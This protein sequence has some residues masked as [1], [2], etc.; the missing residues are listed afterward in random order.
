MSAPDLA[1]LHHENMVATIAQIGRFVPGAVLRE[2]D[3]VMTVLTG[4]PFPLFNQVFV[5]NA[6]G[7]G[8]GTAAAI[9]AGVATARARADLFVVTLRDGIDDQAIAVVRGLGLEP[10]GTSVWMPGMALH[11][12]PDAAPD[13]GPRFA[14]ERAAS[15]EVLDAHIAVA[16]EGFEMPEELLRPIMPPSIL[17]EPET[18]VYVGYEDGVPVVSGLGVRTGRTIGV[19]N[20]ATVPAARQRGYG[21]A[22]T[23]RIAVDGSR[24]GCDVA[25]LQASEMG[26]PIY[27]R[28][29][30]RTVVDYYGW[31][32]RAPEA[33]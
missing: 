27:E 19:Y 24:A 15:T 13:L 5:T 31:A 16:T 25:I 20:I 10:L 21:A 4:L 2:G 33:G 9:A 8:P 32:D 3:G 28:L 6:G 7:P 30:Y 12:L 17:D 14:I 22:I 26:Q 11:P 29:G 1:A 23:T 18:A